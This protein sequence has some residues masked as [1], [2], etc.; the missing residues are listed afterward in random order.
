[1]AWNDLGGADVRHRPSQHESDRF[2]FT[3]ARVTCGFGSDSHNTTRLTQILSDATEDVLIVRYPADQLALGTAALKS[4]RTVLP[5]GALSYWDAESAAIM[6]PGRISSVDVSPI[7]DLDRGERRDAAERLIDDVVS[8]AFAGYGSHYLA[9]PM[10]DA[11]RAV[12]GYQEWAH[13]SLESGKVLVLLENGD[14]IGLA[15]CALEA[16][17]LEI[18]L[19]GVIPSAQGSGRYGVLIGACA[20]LAAGHNL[21]RVIISGQVHNVRAQR[22]W[23]RAGLRP[24]AAVETLHAVRPGLL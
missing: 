19:A 12:E 2:G 4:G 5:A 3:I 6:R 9:N 24:F 16:D 10:F 8:D 23:V 11:T 7:E 18:L 21:P 17:H 1:M 15:T 20:E 13:K 14:P 22:A